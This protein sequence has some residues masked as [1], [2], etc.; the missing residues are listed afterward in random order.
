MVSAQDGQQ[1]LAED[2]V[3]LR[4]AEQ[5]G[6]LQLLVGVAAGGADQ[7]PRRRGLFADL[8]GRAQAV[9]QET[10]Q[11]GRRRAEFRRR[12]VSGQ[13]QAHVGGAIL[14]EPL[15]LLDAGLDVDVVDDGLSLAAAIARHGISS[16]TRRPPSS[17]RTRSARCARERSW[18]TITR[19][20]PSRRRKAKS[21]SPSCRPFSPVEVAERLVQQ[22]D[23]RPVHEGP[24]HGHPLLLAARQLSGK[25]VLAVA[26]AQFPQQF[27]GAGH[28]PPR[29]R[30]VIHVHR[31]EQ[32]LEGGEVRQQ[33]V[34]LEHEARPCGCA[35]GS[36]PGRGP[37]PGAGPRTA[38][39]RRR[40]G[41]VRRRGSGTCSCPTPLGP[42]IAT[43]S[44][45]SSQKS[46]SLQDHRPARR[47][48][49]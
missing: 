45:S 31:H 11:A 5:A 33:E 39:R 46:T 6:V 8:G 35:S 43:A 32:V 16:G 7:G 4:A 28:G 1:V 13:L 36:C 23:A 47:P 9:A 19:A 21:N 12:L 27:A 20:V 30:D 10:V 38:A 41:R 3:A 17:R 49:R 24:R 25:V 34:E 44:P 48:W 22:H 14:A 15:R 42:M 40:A 37:G 29:T 2:H 18:V 26:E